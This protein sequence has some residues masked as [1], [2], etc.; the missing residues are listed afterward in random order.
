MSDELKSSTLKRF[1]HDINLVRAK[2]EDQ[3]VP[4]EHKKGLAI[5]CV[6]F[7]E[8][9]AGDDLAGLTLEQALT[10]TDLVQ[11]FA[12]GAGLPR[13]GPKEPKIL[14]NR[15]SV[16][17]IITAFGKKYQVFR[18]IN[19]AANGYWTIEKCLNEVE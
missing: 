18:A 3:K 13:P 17:R 19:Q 9:Q 5:I 12:V 15:H 16:G 8:Y 10:D 4:V 1:Q 2:I 11:E 14:Y 7:A 6:L